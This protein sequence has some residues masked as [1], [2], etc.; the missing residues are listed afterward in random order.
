LLIPQK[1][2]ILGYAV[3]PEE[4]EEFSVLH[5]RTRVLAL[6]ASLA[7]LAAFAGTVRGW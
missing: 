7:S 4:R 2:Y 6:L 5:W 3:F 1:G